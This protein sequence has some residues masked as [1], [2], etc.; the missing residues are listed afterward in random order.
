MYNFD[1][2]KNRGGRNSQNL[3]FPKAA[4]RDRV[5]DARTGPG[6]PETSRETK[7]DDDEVTR[8]VRGEEDGVYVY[9][10]EG[11]ASASSCSWK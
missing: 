1:V 4:I 8:E 3:S 9:D 6:G 5:E 11:V 7:I 2:N 10:G